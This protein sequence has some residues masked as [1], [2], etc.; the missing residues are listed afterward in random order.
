[1]KYGLLVFSVTLALCATA[2][3]HPGWNPDFDGNR[4]IEMPDLLPFLGI[5]GSEWTGGGGESPLVSE[6]DWLGKESEMLLLPADAQIIVLHA[7]VNDLSDPNQTS[8][9]HRHILVEESEEMSHQVLLMD[10]GVNATNQ[11]MQHG[12]RYFLH[13]PDGTIGEVSTNRVGGMSSS[14]RP[15]RTMAYL[16][17]LNGSCYY[18]Q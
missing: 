14:G 11:P 12:T 3:N 5:F 1:M 4:A 10:R 8:E 15:I 16:M 13:F 7:G 2:Q 9:N 18:G 6:L 17:Q